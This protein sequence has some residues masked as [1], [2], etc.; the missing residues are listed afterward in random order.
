[1]TKQDAGSMG[2]RKTFERYGSQH[3][4]AIGKKGAGVTWERYTLAPVGVSGW[5]MVDRR[6]GEIK[7]LTGYTPPPRNPENIP[8]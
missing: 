7:A 2:G 5:A 1:M 8:F 6:T 3:M 4:R